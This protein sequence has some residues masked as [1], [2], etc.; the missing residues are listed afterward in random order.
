MAL[1]DL[2]LAAQALESARQRITE[3]KGEKE[4]LTTRISAINEELAAA[5]ADS[6]AAIAN[7]KTEAVSVVVP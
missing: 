5:R 6:N 7:I 1:R 2:I 3:L 4:R